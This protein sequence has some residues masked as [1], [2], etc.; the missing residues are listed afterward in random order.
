VFHVP[1]QLAVGGSLREK[2][3]I[4]KVNIKSIFRPSLFWDADEIDMDKH[5]A[6]VIARVLDYG[7]VEDVRKIR[8][9]YPDE[10]IIEA[11]RTRRGMFPKTGKYW[12]V[13][14][15]IPFSEVACLRKYY[16]QKQ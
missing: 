16:Q 6:Y 13:K 2:L 14:F 1:K 10:K 11:I 15:N 5:A 8:E 12:A 3:Y 9:L 7:D 4:Q